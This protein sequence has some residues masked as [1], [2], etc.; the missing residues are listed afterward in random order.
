M[1]IREKNKSVHSKFIVSQTC[2]DESFPKQTKEVTNN[3]VSKSKKENSLRVLF[4]LKEVND[5]SLHFFRTLHV[6]N[7]I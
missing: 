2:S 4:K 5:V 6:F 1:R 3:V 7:R